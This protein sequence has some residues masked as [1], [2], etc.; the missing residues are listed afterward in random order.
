MNDSLP[1]TPAA[2]LQ[3]IADMMLGLP[4]HDADGNPTGER[5]PPMIT[6]EQ[7]REMLLAIPDLEV[8]DDG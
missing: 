5:L 6:K 1:K 7:A 3:F 8:R 2:R 4:L